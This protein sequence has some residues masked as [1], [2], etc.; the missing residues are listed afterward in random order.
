MQGARALDSLPSLASPSTQ[1]LQSPTLDFEILKLVPNPTGK[2]LAVV[3]T[4]QVAVVILPRPGYV[5]L[6]GQ[7]IDCR[8]VLSSFLRTNPRR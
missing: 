5:N 1:A 6:V 7:T 4:H 2:L 3:G 8:R